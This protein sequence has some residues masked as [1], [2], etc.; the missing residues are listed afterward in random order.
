MRNWTLSAI[1]W[2]GLLIPVWALAG[3]PA[4]KPVDIRNLMTVTQF[5]QAGLDKL[6][7]AELAALNAWLSDYTQERVQ[8]QAAMQPA[9]AASPAASTAVF[10]AEMLSPKQ[11]HEPARIETRIAGM[12]NGW[13]GNTIFPLENGQVWKQASSGYFTDL[14]LDHPQVI[15]KK[16]AFGYLL[17]IPGQ[18]ETVFVRRIK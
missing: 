12:F 1:A 13:T 10:G 11:T 7:P 4:S 15:I 17:T 5:T 2:V 9:T 18:S 6:S 16:L 8:P 14:K 3:A